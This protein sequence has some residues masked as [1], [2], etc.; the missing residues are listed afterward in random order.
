MKLENIKFKAKRLENKEWVCGYFYQENDNTYIV[1]DRQ[2]ESLL[3]RNAAYEVDP[4]T[5]CQFTGLKDKKGKE[6]YEGD[7]IRSPYI[8][9]EYAIEWGSSCWFNIPDEVNGARQS[10]CLFLYS[11]WYVVGNKFDKEK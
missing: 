1:E 9:E 4:N 2:K 10:L 5:V 6:V 3:N 8:R 7:I 11:G